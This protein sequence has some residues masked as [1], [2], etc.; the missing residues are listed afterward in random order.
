MNDKLQR[1]GETESETEFVSY[2][3]AGT[4][5]PRNLVGYVELPPF[6]GRIQAGIRVLTHSAAVA[7]PSPVV[8][9]RH[10]RP[11]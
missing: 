8:K 5:G 10:P 3:S 4:D 2:T 1:F 6:T 7:G 9:L 11:W